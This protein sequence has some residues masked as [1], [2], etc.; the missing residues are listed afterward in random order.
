MKDGRGKR[1]R[2]NRDPQRN[3]ETE[4]PGEGRKLRGHEGWEETEKRHTGAQINK[5]T[6]RHRDS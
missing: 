5:D 6:Q 2:R 3:S 1:K 4:N